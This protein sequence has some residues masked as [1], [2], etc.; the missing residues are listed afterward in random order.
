[1]RRGLLRDKAPAPKSVRVELLRAKEGVDVR[2]QAELE[3]ADDAKD[4]TKYVI[5]MRQEGLDGLKKIQADVPLPPSA[6]A[7][8]RKTLESIQIQPKGAGVEGAIF[9]PTEALL[10][11]PMWF[12]G[13]AGDDRLPPPPPPPPKDKESRLAPLLRAP[14]PG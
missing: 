1:M 14:V 2:F 5:K 12:L 8:M 11:G 6:I 10:T 7:A 3:N 13:R 9:V 4:F